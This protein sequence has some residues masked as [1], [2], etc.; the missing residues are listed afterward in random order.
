VTASMRGEEGAVEEQKIT[1]ARREIED[2]YGKIGDGKKILF[3]NGVPMGLST[4]SRRLALQYSD[5]VPIDAGELADGTYW[6]RIYDNEQRKVM[7]V[8]FDRE[9]GFTE[10]AGRTSWT[11]SGT[12]TSASGGA[13]SARRAARSGWAPTR[14]GE[15]AENEAAFP[16][17][18]VGGSGASEEGSP[19]EC[20]GPVDRGGTAAREKGTGKTTAVRS[21]AAV[22]PP[23]D[24]VTGCRFCCVRGTLLCDE[25]R[26]REASGEALRYE[27]RPV[28]VVDL[29]LNASEDR[30]VGSL[31]LEAALREGAGSS[32]WACWGRRTG[33]CCTSTR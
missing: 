23:K 27:S 19:G 15:R 6:L 21:F 29:A 18:R 24:V 9:Y 16:L 31:D 22:L 2:R 3:V 28:E 33:T 30:V 13:P 5:L 7:V 25:C 12:T 32:R 17:Q 20:G 14:A 26:A 11:G 8:E 10:S 1:I 4:L